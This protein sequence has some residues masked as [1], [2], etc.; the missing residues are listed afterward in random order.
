MHTRGAPKGNKNALK[1]GFYSRHFRQAE[2]QDLD[3]LTDASTSLLSE[4][5]ALRVAA[6][7]MSEALYT[8][9]IE[10]EAI[11]WISVLNALGLAYNRIAGL[12]KTQKL[13][14]GDHQPG[15][16]IILRP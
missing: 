14:E 7:R 5:A 12:L 8:N 9:Q 6:R 13:L 10:G 1:H 4:I 3:V 11:D 2:L 16:W 15:E